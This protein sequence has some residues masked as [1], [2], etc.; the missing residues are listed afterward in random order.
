MR[1]TINNQ[2]FQKFSEVNIG[3]LFAQDI[4][5]NDNSDVEIKELIREKEKEIKNSFTVM[6]LLNIPRINAWRKAYSAFGAKPK[7]YKCSVENLYRMILSGKELHTI[8]KIVD[9]Y[10]YISIKNMIPIGGDDYDKIDGD[11]T[12]TFSRGDEAFIELNSKEKKHPKQGEVIYKD[13]NEVLCRRWNWRECDK[14]KMVDQTKN[15]LFFVEGIAPVSDHE[16]KT[17]VDQLST[18][19]KKYCGGKT[20][21]HILNIKNPI[22]EIIASK[23]K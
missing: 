11:I 4:N 16:V 21:N 13:D 19:V 22:V 6:E 3:I 12:L 23:T 14:T 17:V 15:V 9:I 1:I 10:N 5:N 20:Q 7:K 18:M 2:I 8:N